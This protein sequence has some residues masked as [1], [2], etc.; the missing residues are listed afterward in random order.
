MYT[1][2][3]K[4]GPHPMPSQADWIV[5]HRSAGGYECWFCT[6]CSKEISDGHLKTEKHV[7]NVSWE[8]DRRQEVAAAA[9]EAAALAAAA[10]GSTLIALE[11][12]AAA[13]APYF[14]PFPSTSPRASSSTD[15]TIS[16]ELP[17][18]V[19]TSLQRALNAALGP[20]R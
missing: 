13:S 20:T 1:N 15:A 9:A 5:E 4:R 17:V 3:W 7:K 14:Q 18:A 12:R 2:K 10:G 11:D 8:M 19:A 6:L 16:I